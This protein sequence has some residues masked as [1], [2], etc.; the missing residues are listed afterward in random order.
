MWG[1]LSDYTALRRDARFIPTYVGLTPRH[2]HTRHI[3]AVHPHVCG[4]YLTSPRMTDEKNGSSPRM[5]GLRVLAY[6]TN[7]D[8]RF[9]PTYVGLTVLA[10]TRAPNQP[11]HPHVCGAYI[12]SSI[13][14]LSLSGSSPRMWG[15]QFAAL[16]QLWKHRFI[17][18]YVGLTA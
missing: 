14:F 12:D 11:V 9:I 18:T 16:G 15:L 13:I 3:V 1:L 4:A 7:S 17:P 2:T 8:Q 6:A 5:W 10:C